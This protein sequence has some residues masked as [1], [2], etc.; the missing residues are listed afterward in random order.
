MGHTGVIVQ[1]IDSSLAL[2]IFHLEKRGKEEET[3]M[4]GRNEKGE[5]SGRERKERR[6]NESGRE[7][8]DT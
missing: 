1:D 8:A 4:K 6:E 7:R 3:Q 5:G 2:N